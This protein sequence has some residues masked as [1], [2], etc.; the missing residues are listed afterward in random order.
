M[1]A[2]LAP[3][4]SFLTILALVVFAAGCTTT[5]PADVLAVPAAPQK[6]AAI[7]AD[8]RTG[9]QLFEVNST[10]PRYPASLT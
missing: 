7:V 1:S 2:L 3:F 9:K 4:R 8:A 5:T 6:Y 10:A